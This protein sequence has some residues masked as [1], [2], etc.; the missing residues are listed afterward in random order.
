MICPICF[1]LWRHH[2]PEDGR[3]DSPSTERPDVCQC[4]RDLDWMR[5]KIAG[6]SRDA[7]RAPEGG[8]IPS[9]GI[10]GVTDDEVDGFLAADP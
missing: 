3:C 7:L 1:H 6:L 8:P 10:E 5:T 2:D 9:S 4:G